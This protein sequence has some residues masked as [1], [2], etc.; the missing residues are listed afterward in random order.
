MHGYRY[1]RLCRKSD[2]PVVQRPRLGPYKVEV[3]DFSPN[4]T[5]SFRQRE[6][7]SAAYEL[8]DG[9]TQTLVSRLSIL[10]S[11]YLF[12][13][14]IMSSMPYVITTSGKQYQTEG[15]MLGDS[16]LIISRVSLACGPCC[17]GRG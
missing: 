9:T 6:H 2:T 14:T 12:R 4:A 10:N 7:Q 8:E 3:L 16:S 11:P 5:F 15:V 17:K 1:A 13:K